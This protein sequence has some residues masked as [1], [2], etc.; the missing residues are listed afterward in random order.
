LYAAT[1]DEDTRGRMRAA[2]FL[3]KGAAREPL[4]AQQP[5]AL[6]AGGAVC[7]R[8]AAQHVGG[9][10]QLRVGSGSAWKQGKRVWSGEEDV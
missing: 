4:A 7:E 6:P 8:P 9:S 1:D 3:G 2:F 5:A 10:S